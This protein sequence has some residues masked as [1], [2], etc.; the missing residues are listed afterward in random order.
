LYRQQ[1]GWACGSGGRDGRDIGNFLTPA[2]ADAGRNF[3]TPE[4]FAASRNRLDN[5]EPGDKIEEDRLLRNLLTSQTL[6]F[7]L[8]VPQLLDL[9]LATLIWKTL[10]PQRVAHVVDVKLEHSPGRC[11]ATR[12]TGDRSAFDAFV[13]YVH[14]DGQ[15][16]V[17]GIETKYTDAFSAPCGPPTPRHDALAAST[18]LYTSEG[19]I[20][21][22]KMRSQQLWRTH[23]LAET[24]RDDRRRHVTYMVL[25]AA[26]DVECTSVLPEYEAAL[27]LQAV[28]EG[29]F[30]HMTLED[31]VATARPVLG[32]ADGMWL[33][34]FHSRYLDW[35][36]VE[37]AIGPA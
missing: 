18:G 12:Y 31:F 35:K 1:K 37:S 8:F 15:R 30:L 3:L 14:I 29:R 17:L 33:D 22:Q 28:A 10:L 7:N 27:T 23:L 25:H 2:D 24:M 5:R 11:D 19:W 16:G 34:A 26:G 36:G 13:E 9:R 21:L 6:C 20:Q 32:G 4:I